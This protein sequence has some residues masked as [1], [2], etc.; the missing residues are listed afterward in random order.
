MSGSSNLGSG[1]SYFTDI[2]KGSG[3]S[4]GSGSGSSTGSGSGSSSTSKTGSG[5]GSSSTFIN[6]STGSS[7]YFN[8]PMDNFSYT[9]DSIFNKS[10]ITLVVWFLA[11]YIILYITIS[12]F[13]S[14]D[15]KNVN[16]DLSKS[17]TIDFIVL[18]L[19][20]VFSI[21]YYFSLS[22]EDKSDVVGYVVD[23]CV[24]EL[25]HPEALGTTLLFIISFY[26]MVFLLGIP[27]TYEAT[28]ITINIIEQKMWI[29]LTMQLISLFFIY[30]L[31]IPLV[32]NLY[33]MS[34]DWWNKTKDNIP[35]PQ[36]Y[37]DEIKKSIPI[38]TNEVFNVGNNLYTYD[39]AQAICKSYNAKLATYDQIEQAYNSGAEW[40]NYGWSEGQMAF[41]P[42]QKATWENLQKDPSTKNNC[43]RPGVNGGYIDNPYV[44]FGVNCYGKKPTAKDS[45]SAAFASKQTSPD[46][47]IPLT[48]EQQKVQDK[49][50]Y[51]K[52]NSDQLQLNSFN[53]KKWSQ[54]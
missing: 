29:W 47:A 36:E 17:R 20:L 27:M 51:W 38:E 30:V 33:N 37:V 44:R 15:T 49:I 40:C 32:E 2:R 18:T 34:K 54:Y 10:N 13:T 7:N 9:F 28:P 46:T 1:S 43:G 52:E 11:I 19:L 4:I 50:N 8:I 25:I 3:S 48:P 24:Y 45:D 12:L 31:G 5:S 14:K 23:W 41:F 22:E 16:P 6:V 35:N 26:L 21:S 53:N 42:T 39:D